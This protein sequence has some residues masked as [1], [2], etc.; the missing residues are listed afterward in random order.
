MAKSP[1]DLLKSGKHHFFTQELNKALEA[2]QQSLEAN[3]PNQ[4][5][6]EEAEAKLSL[7][8]TLIQEK[9]YVN[10]IAPLLVAK[11]KS[12][13]IQNEEILAQACLQI[14]I[15]Y[16]QVFHYPKALENLYLVK[17]SYWNALKAPDQVLLLNH[18]GKSHFL[19]FEN[20]AA[21]VHF[22][23]AAQIAEQQ[24]HKP[25]LVFA[26]SYLGR[27]YAVRKNFKKALIYA[28]KANDIIEKIGDT[29]G[30]Q[31]NLI[32]LGDIHQPIGKI[33]RGY[34][35]SQ[36]RNRCGEANER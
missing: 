3:S 22:D 15:L 11:E 30:V 33:Q 7:G 26:Y 36:S 27:L 35:T 5:R 18:L 12:N 19:S 21:E 32:S 20:E 25:A 24:R 2:V 29:E 16:N 13:Q 6:R 31:V 23:N 28:K 14:G 1:D 8:K 17:D 34:K 9:E 4:S 10:A